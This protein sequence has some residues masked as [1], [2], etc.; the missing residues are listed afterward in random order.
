M[1]PARLIDVNP[2][3]AFLR[4]VLKLTPAAFRALI[5]EAHAVV[6]DS[7]AGL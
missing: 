3:F 2:V 6:F 4:I 7:E 5:F 1:I